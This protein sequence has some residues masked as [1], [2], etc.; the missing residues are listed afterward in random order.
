[1]N[2]TVKMIAGAAAGL[3]CAALLAYV[4]FLFDPFWPPWSH[5]Y[6]PGVCLGVVLAADLLA[7]VSF[8]WWIAR[9]VR[10]GSLD[11]DAPK[12]AASFGT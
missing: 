8:V 2:K 11:R 4:I 3:F 6:S 9:A 5:I 7:L 10:G 12:S 1:M